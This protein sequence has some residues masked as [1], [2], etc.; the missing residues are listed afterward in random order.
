MASWGRLS[1]YRQPVTARAHDLPARDIDVPCVAV[2]GVRRD[3]PSSDGTRPYPSGGGFALF[4]LPPVGCRRRLS[5]RPDGKTCGA[6]HFAIAPYVLPC[7]ARRARSGNQPTD[8]EGCRGRRRRR[9]RRRYIEDK[10]IRNR[11]QPGYGDSVFIRRYRMGRG[12]GVVDVALLPLKGPH[13]LVLIEA[14]QSVTQDVT[15]KVIGQLLMYYAGALCVGARGDS[16]HE[17]FRRTR[18]GPRPKSAPPNRSRC[19]RVA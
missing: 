1:L 3:H 17:N 13:R 16:P 2:R 18:P 19:F 11:A 7:F 6:I 5:R 8:R 15:S 10:V 14:K 12:Y 9:R 4:H